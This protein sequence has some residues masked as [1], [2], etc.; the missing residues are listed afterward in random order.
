METGRMRKGWTAGMLLACTAL[1]GCLE[2][3]VRVDHAGW[4]HSALKIEIPAGMIQAMVQS[5]G[6]AIPGQEQEPCPDPDDDNVQDLMNEVEKQFGSEDAGV[7]IEDWTADTTSRPGSVICEYRMSPVHPLQMNATARD[8]WGIQEDPEGRGWLV[9]GGKPTAEE[10]R[11]G[12]EAMI[13]MIEGCTEMG[14]G[15]APAAAM[16]APEWCDEDTILLAEKAMA[17]DPDAI[18][19]LEAMGQ[20]ID[21]GEDAAMAMVVMT[22]RIAGQV[23]PVRGFGPDPDGDGYMYRGTLAQL[24]QEKPAY[25]VLYVKG[26]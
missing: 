21:L 7:D 9:V 17:G 2:Q 1:A 25:R 8:A 5:K 13:E 18:E 16:G 14:E 6:G 26:R 22:V 15:G 23:E 12:S 24:E 20:F 10:P 11:S 19:A 3:N 4:I